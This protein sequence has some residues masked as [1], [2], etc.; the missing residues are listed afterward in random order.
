[1]KE[2]AVA[3]EVFQKRG[4]RLEQIAVSGSSE[5]LQAVQILAGRR[6]PGGVVAGR[7][8]GYSGI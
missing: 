8:Y 5:V 6:Y 7:Q 1:V 2:Q 4:I 3:R